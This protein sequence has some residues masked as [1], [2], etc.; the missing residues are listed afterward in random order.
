MNIRVGSLIQHVVF[1]KEIAMVIA[2]D[3]EHECWV[4]VWDF[5][6]PGLYCLT[7]ERISRSWRIL[8]K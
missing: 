3:Y 6:S 2:I 7:Y 1:E 5:V 8:C 4:E